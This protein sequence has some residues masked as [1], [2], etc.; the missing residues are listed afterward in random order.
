[1]KK[2]FILLS[3]MALCAAAGAQTTY[4]VVYI[5]GVG[6]H[7]FGFSLAPTYNPQHLGVTFESASFASSIDAEG[8]VTN[9]IGVNAGLFYGYETVGNTI[10]WGNYTSLFYGLTPFSGTVS[11][12][13][14]DY[15]INYLS[16]RIMLHFNP[17]LAYRINDQFS[18]SAGLGLSLAPEF[19]SSLTLNGQRLASDADAEASL[20]SQILSIYI[21]GNAGVKYWFSDEMFV[22][23]RVQYA[24]ANVINLLGKMDEESAEVLSQAN[25]AISID[26]D[27]NTW[28]STIL[29]RNPIYA[30]LSI[31]Y[32]W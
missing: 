30:V 24:F 3:F 20:F 10:D 8:F 32:V 17:F 18:V 29:P 4:R 23:L 21:D 5:P 22:G 11:L 2:A 7:Q 1:M 25:G 12:N 9:M 27:K 31:G 6:E 15:K 19:A 14:Q 28:R 13:T 26:L 16:H